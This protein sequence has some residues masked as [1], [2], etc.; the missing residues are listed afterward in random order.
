[1][2]KYTG[3]H[4]RFEFIGTYQ[5]VN[6]YDDYGHHPTEIRATAMALKKKQYNH[7]WV[8]F[9]PHTYS[10]TQNLLDD[11]ALS[12]TNFD[13]II[14]TDIYAAREVNTYNVSS[15][16]LVN[17][18]KSLGKNAIYISNFYDIVNYLKQHIQKDDII[19]TL[20]AGTVFQIGSMF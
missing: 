11:F 16:D 19:L 2:K 3:A 1:M 4:R 7:S 17:K 20:G 18:I 9:Q 12:L 5:G 10:R 8:V 6:I 15:Q 13:N 14:V